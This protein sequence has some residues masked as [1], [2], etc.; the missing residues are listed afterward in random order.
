MVSD[1]FGRWQE[2]PQ[3][4]ILLGCA[5]AVGGGRRA[6]HSTCAG[7]WRESLRYECTIYRQISSGGGT[8]VRTG[9][10]VEYLVTYFN[11]TQQEGGATRRRPLEIA[12][13]P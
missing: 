6:R 2:M 1:E 8:T 7:Y 4:L 3:E 11:L 5:V 10:H 12:S 9:F 13:G